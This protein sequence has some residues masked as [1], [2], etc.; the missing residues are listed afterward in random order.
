M[1][2][3]EIR[4][5]LDQTL[6]DR[7]LSRSERRALKEVLGDLALT[8]EER[9][10]WIGRAFESARDALRHPDEQRVLG[11]LED[12]VKTLEPGP[13]GMPA[14][15]EAYFEPIQDCAQRLRELFGQS[16]MSVDICVFTITD[17]SLVRAIKDAHGRGVNV[18]I[19][20]DD[21]KS[22]DPGSDI[23]PLREAGIEV[24]L[25][26]SIDH[27]HHKFAVFDRRLLVN[28]SYNWTRSA[29]RGNYENIALSDNSRLVELYLAEFDRLWEEFAPSQSSDT[30]V[31]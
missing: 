18:R 12:V 3:Q 23:E 20:S 6:E 4:R 26:R 11:W 16:H 2:Q 15:A 31:Q 10:A 21:L 28:G 5:L 24:R 29:S 13:A 25:D 27:M 14:I 8:P 30:L 7:R 19:L 22:L 9:L 17:N 1:N